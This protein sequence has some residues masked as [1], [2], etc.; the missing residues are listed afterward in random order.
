MAGVLAQL[1]RLGTATD[2]RAF[3]ELMTSGTRAG[4]VFAGFIGLAVRTV[5]ILYWARA[6]WGVDRREPTPW[7]EVEE[8]T[9]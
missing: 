1:A 8:G 6:G 3:L 7:S 5:A 2:E 9:Q 4:R